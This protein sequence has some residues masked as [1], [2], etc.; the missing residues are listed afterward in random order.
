MLP[1]GAILQ[2]QHLP[3]SHATPVPPEVSG[4]LGPPSLCHPNSCLNPLEA[5]GSVS[6]KPYA[7]LVL[8][9]D[10]FDSSFKTQLTSHLFQE[11]FQ[12]FFSC[13]F[14]PWQDESVFW[15]FTTP[16]VQ[17]TCPKHLPLCCSSLSGGRGRGR[18]WWGWRLEYHV[19]GL[20]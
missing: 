5:S 1:H 19:P 2:R 18:R 3:A 16:D 11:A 8:S 4:S 9:A 20:R 14:P 10:H 17:S 15:V 12:D 7:V 13:H 6:G